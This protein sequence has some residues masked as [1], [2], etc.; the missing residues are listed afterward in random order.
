DLSPRNRRGPPRR[1]LQKHGACMESL[2]Q[3]AAI[4]PDL[5]IEVPNRRNWFSLGLDQLPATLA[6][7]IEAWLAADQGTDPRL[8]R[9][10]LNRSAL[11]HR[12]PIR[13]KTA[14]SYERIMLEFITM[15]VRARIPLDSL[16]TL[17]DVVDPQN[18]DRGLAEYERHFGGQKRRHLGQVMRIVC[19][20]ARH[21]VGL[22]SEQV[23]ELWAWAKDVGVA[24]HGMTSKNKSLLLSLRD[25]HAL[26]RL[27]GLGPKVVK[28]VLAKPRIQKTEAMRAQ[29]AF[30]IAL[31]LNAPA[32]IGNI[33]SIHLDRHLRRVGMGG[34]EQIFLEFCA[35]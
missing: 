29:V 17:A 13:P 6:A 4:V 28:E 10:R 19:L 3:L 23:S 1:D 12:K 35:A 30:A 33:A 5:T 24:R 27:L 32:R 2:E 14:E 18:V 9:A 31:L 8:R 21:W 15:E 20:V 22:N 16:R 26:A 34:D 25:P 7:D 11:P